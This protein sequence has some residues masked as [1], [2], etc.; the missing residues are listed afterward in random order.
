MRVLQ[1]LRWVLLAI[2]MLSLSGCSDP[3]VYGSIGVSS[4]YGSYGGWGS[5]VHTSISVGGRIR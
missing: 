3:H 5:G 4:G 2:V 1:R